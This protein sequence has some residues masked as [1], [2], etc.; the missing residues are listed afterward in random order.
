MMPCQGIRVVGKIEKLE[1]FELEIYFQ[2]LV[3]S[4]RSRSFHLPFP[5]TCNPVVSIG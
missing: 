5:T 4:G 1:I 2:V 3:F